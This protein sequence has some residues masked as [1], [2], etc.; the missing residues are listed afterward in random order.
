MKYFKQHHLCRT[1]LQLIL[2]R[3]ADL[4]LCICLI[5]PSY[6]VPNGTDLTTLKYFPNVFQYFCLSSFTMYN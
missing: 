3:L 1:N 4:P 2:W 6:I 5:T